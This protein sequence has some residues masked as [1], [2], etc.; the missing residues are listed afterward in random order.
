VST[1]FARDDRRECAAHSPPPA[2]VG[3]SVNAS[4]AAAASHQQSSDSLIELWSLEP[5]DAAA[6]HAYLDAFA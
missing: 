2:D 4:A 3:G 5:A 1:S 6:W